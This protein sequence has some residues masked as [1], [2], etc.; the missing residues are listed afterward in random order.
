MNNY[1]AK[2]GLNFNPFIKNTKDIIYQSESYVQGAIRLKRLFE[3]KG[4]GVI[5]GEPGSGKTSLVRSFVKELS[6]KIY[7]VVYISLSTLSTTEFYRNLAIEL[8]LEPKYRKSD[9]YR[10][11]QK[12]IKEIHDS[13]MVPVIILDEADYLNRD[14]MHDLKM[15]LNFNMDSV[16]RVI[17]ILIGQVDMMNQFAHKRNSSISQRIVMNYPITEL[18]PNEIKE[19][20]AEKLKGAGQ[21]LSIVDDD[22]YVL[23]ENYSEGKMRMINKIMD[24]AMFIASN[25]ND[26]VVTKEDVEIALT[27]VMFN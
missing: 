6:S 24:Q 16:D 22:A 18:N 5:T 25:K 27:E 9:N 4:I 14:I 26:S 13:K 10:N 2:F 11:I 7:K 23:I 3:L 21:L 8:G 19:Y 20:I 1:Y 15:L 12:E 17:L